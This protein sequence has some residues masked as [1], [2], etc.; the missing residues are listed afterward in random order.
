M[1][2]PAMAAAAW[3][4]ACDHSTVGM[5]RGAIVTSAGRQAHLAIGAGKGLDL[6]RPIG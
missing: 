1:T 5:R 4:P 3:K 6:R 2:I